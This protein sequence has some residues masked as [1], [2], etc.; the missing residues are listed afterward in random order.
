[1]FFDGLL[2]V[3]GTCLSPEMPCEGSTEGGTRR[4]GTRRRRNKDLV[5]SRQGPVG[6]VMAGSLQP[7]HLGRRRSGQSVNVKR[8]KR[9]H[10]QDSQLLERRGVRFWGGSPI[11]G[12]GSSLLST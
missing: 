5:L 6:I 10:P 2:L 11:R 12:G 1:M 7:S 3:R 9:A 8:N 4:K